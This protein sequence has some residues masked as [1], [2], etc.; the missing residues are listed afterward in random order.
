MLLKKIDGFIG[1]PLAYLWPKPANRT[2]PTLS[3]ANI[4][5][6]RPGG[7]GDAVLL[8]PVIDHLRKVYP[9]ACIELLAE[10]RNAG[11]FALCRGVD[12]VLYYDKPRELWALLRRKYDV[13]IDSEQWHRLSAIVARMIRSRVKIGYATNERKRLFTHPVDYSH[14]HYELKSFFELLAPLAI[15]P[16]ATTATPFLSVPEKSRA[17]ADLLLGTLSEQPFVAIFPGAS[18]AERR[19]GA[20]KFS[21]LTCRLMEAGHPVV[22]VGGREDVEEGDAIVEGSGALNLAGKSSLME[23]A[24]ILKRAQ[25]LVS[26]DSGVL[27]IGVGLGVPTVSLFGPGIAD[28]WAPRG[29][30]HI[31]LNHRLPCSP[32]TRFGTTPP[33]PIGGK[34]IQDISVGEVFAAVERLLLEI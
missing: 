12:N 4:L 2:L 26:G 10:Q 30:R 5:L 13:V 7:I 29:N 34:C 18:I 9:D 27:H 19:W 20:S 3:T 8:I 24:G 1:S 14:E 11:T 6:I 16:P 31:V 28:K 32:C 33:C 22:V 23:T 17:S 21:D 15:D 25:L